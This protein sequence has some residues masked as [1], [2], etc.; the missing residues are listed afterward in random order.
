MSYQ[1]RGTPQP[2]TFQAVPGFFAQDT[3]KANPECTAAVSPVKLIQVHLMS[4][5]PFWLSL[6][7]H[8]LCS[9]AAEL[10]TVLLYQLLPRFGLLHRFPTWEVFKSTIDGL[11]ANADDN[12]AYK[13][14]FL[15]RHG[16]G[17]RE[18]D[19]LLLDRPPNPS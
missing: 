2:T 6:D 12:V 13:V 9:Q 8:P 4:L 15:G 17:F 1:L 18:L 19:S 11:N 5:D 7:C 10:I 3:P 14:L 16:E